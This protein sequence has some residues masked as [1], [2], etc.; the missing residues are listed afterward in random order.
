MKYRN[1]IGTDNVIHENGKHYVK[2]S[3][4]RWFTNLKKSCYQASINKEYSPEAYPEYDNYKAIE[5]SK[6]KDIPNYYGWVSRLR[7]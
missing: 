6:V 2:L 7:L 5:V 4:C 3:F 1:P